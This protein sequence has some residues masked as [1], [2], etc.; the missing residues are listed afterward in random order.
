MRSILFL[1]ITLSLLHSAISKSMLRLRKGASIS[2]EGNTFIISPDN[3]FTC[4]F[5]AMPRSNAYW[6]S[7]WFTN[8][9]DKTVVWTANRDKPVNSQRSKISIQRDGTMVLT[10]VDGSIT[11]QTDKRAADVSAAELLNTGNLVLKNPQGNILWQSFDVP[12]DTLL[13]SQILTKDIRLLSSLRK[14]SFE[15]GYFNLYFDSDNVLMLTSDSPE[16]SSIYWPYPGVNIYENGRT[17]YNASRRAV[18]DDM[19]TFQSSDNFQ[20]NASDIGFGIKRRLT[21]DN[22]G[23]LR[24]YSL[25]N[26]TGLWMITWQAISQ[27]CQVHGVCGRYAICVYALKPKCICT[28]GFEVNNPSDWSAGCKPAFRESLLNSLVKFVEVSRTDYFGFDFDFKPNFTLEACREFCSGDSR[29]KAFTYKTWGAGSCYVKSEL[30]NGLMSP[31][32]PGSTYI[33]LPYRL[34]VS[35]PSFFNGSST[36][37]ESREAD[38]LVGSPSMYDFTRTTVR[39]VYIYSFCGA[40][41]AIELIF[42]V[43]GWWFLFRK[44]GVPASVEAGYRMISSQFKRFSYDEL[45]KGTNNFREELGRGGSGIVYKGVLADDRVVAVKRLGDVF[46]GQ[47][48]F[49]AEIRTIGKINHMNLVRMWGFCS[50]GRQRL[51]VYE[52]VDNLSLDKHL[53]HSNFLGWKQRF[54]VALGTAKGLAYLHDECLEWV[55]HCDVKPENILL[56]GELQPKIADFGL[57]KLSRRDGSGSDISNIRGTKGYMAPEWALN[58]PITAKVDVYSY[59][60]VVLEMIK[61]IKLSNWAVDDTEDREIPLK[62]FVRIA[63]EKIQCGNSY[64]VDSIVDP[65]LEGRFSRNQAATLIEIGLSCVEENRNKRPMMASIV[66]TLMECEDET[67]I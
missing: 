63:K 19:G 52:Y 42:I 20:A 51:L 33:K 11:W 39:W 47:D 6:F 29:C 12:T 66:Q 28:P 44:H 31:D 10:D 14:G 1:L 45:K 18:L 9:K 41:G 59:G 54:A 34:H 37:C 65:R 58:C 21:L 53:F 40:L 61:G 55:I 57:A 24:I 5:Y 8:S 43:V 46:Q 4:G 25:I 2:V 7:I 50:E 60:V 35:K 48:E 17:N 56:D 13:P 23:N 64:W 62:S 27:P 16:T 26:S 30:F 32:F 67:E 49:W 3:S 15:T 38:I 22:D 36:M